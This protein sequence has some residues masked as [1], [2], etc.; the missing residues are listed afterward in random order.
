MI[1]RLGPEALAASVLGVNVSFVLLLFSIGVVIATAPMMAQ[2]LGRRR[3]AVREPR[4]TVRQGLWVALALGLPAW[5]G[6]LEH[7]PD[8]A[9]VASGPG[10]DPAAEPYVHAAMW[11]FVPALW[12]VVL[13]NFI[14]ALE[15]PRAGM[16]VMLLG[17][18]FN[19]LGDYALI[20]GAFGLPAMGLRGAGIATALTNLGLFLG[21]ARFRAAR[22]P[23]PALPHP[24]ALL[25]PGLGAP[26][27]DLP[28]RPADRPDAG[29]GGRA[30]RGRRLPDRADRA[31]RARRAPDRAAMRER[32][33][34]GAAR[35]RPGGD[36]AGRARGR[37]RRS[38]GR[39]AR[40]H[41]RARDRR[42]V[43]D[44]DRDLDVDRAE[45]D[46]RAVHRCRRSGQRPGACGW[47]SRSSRS[48]RCSRSST[49]AR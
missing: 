45:G 19:A 14:A 47:R 17:V 29:H 25:A 21:P 23:L 46:H 34:H 36:R 10:P 31:G 15:R 12:F 40:R 6:A 28:P 38:G 22:P 4:R 33:L 7:R 3:H 44:R 5:A 48:R 32:R 1:G 11:G 30:V 42:P 37:P 39:G 35:P 8:P 2:D 13:R 49:A 43:H 24:R 16:V 9:S 20:F 26:A 41:H 27:R 18:A